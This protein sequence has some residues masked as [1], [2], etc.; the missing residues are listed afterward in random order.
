[1]LYKDHSMKPKKKHKRCKF[2]MFHFHVI[3]NKLVTF[4]WNGLKHLL[5]SEH[6]LT[7]SRKQTLFYKWLG[8]CVYKRQHKTNRKL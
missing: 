4:L 1:M 3:N 5:T 2:C 7:H 6:P 8:K